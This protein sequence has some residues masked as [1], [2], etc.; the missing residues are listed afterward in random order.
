MVDFRFSLIA[1]L[2]CSAVA[3]LAGVKGVVPVAAVWTLL[4]AGFLLRALQGRR[5]GGR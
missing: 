1:G 2:A 3:V 5:R 4:A